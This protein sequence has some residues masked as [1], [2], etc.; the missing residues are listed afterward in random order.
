LICDALTRPVEVKVSDPPAPTVI[1]AVVFVPLVIPLNA[2]DEVV[3]M[4]EEESG[5]VQASKFEDEIERRPKDVAGLPGVV[6]LAISTLPLISAAN[7]GTAR[8][9]ARRNLF[10]L[11]HCRTKRATPPPLTTAAELMQTAFDAVAGN[12]KS[13]TNPS[14]L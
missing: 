2:I 4:H 9:K 11:S 12:G 13:I 3:G 6:I 14:S 7:I 8:A 1:V 5:F 10:I